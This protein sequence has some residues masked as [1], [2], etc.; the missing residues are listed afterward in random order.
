MT[1]IHTDMHY[2]DV[3]NFSWLRN[4]LQMVTSLLKSCC[5]S[6]LRQ[7]QIGIYE[8]ALVIQV[9][10]AE[11]IRDGWEITVESEKKV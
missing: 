7:N 11:A 5:N 6:R 9:N 8:A 4:R 3:C 2:H 1:I 10:K